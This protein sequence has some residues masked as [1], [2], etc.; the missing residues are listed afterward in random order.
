MFVC[1]S[2]LY[3]S[4]SLNLNLFDPDRYDWPWLGWGCWY[5]SP[6]FEWLP[7]VVFALL[8]M[9]ISSLPKI[10]PYSEKQKI[11]QFVLIWLILHGWLSLFVRLNKKGFGSDLNPP[12]L[13]QLIEVILD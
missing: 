1:Y 11:E 7:A 9:R 5:D 10:G 13:S 6:N 8:H 3:T 12:K 2:F 4:I